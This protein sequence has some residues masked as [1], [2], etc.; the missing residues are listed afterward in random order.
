MKGR[1][2]SVV[3]T[4]RQAYLLLL[5][6]CNKIGCGEAVVVAVWAAGGGIYFPQRVHY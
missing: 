3:A 1:K 2:G 4:I 5:L 6:Q